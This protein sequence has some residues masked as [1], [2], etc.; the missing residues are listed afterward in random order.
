MVPIEYA[1]PSRHPQVRFRSHRA[2]R[3]LACLTQPIVPLL[4]Q[5]WPLRPPTGPSIMLGLSSATFPRFSSLLR[6]YPPPCAGALLCPAPSLSSPCSGAL[7]LHLPCFCATLA[8]FLFLPRCSILH[9]AGALPRAWLEL[10][11]PLYRSSRWRSARVGAGYAQRIA[12]A[13][14]D[15]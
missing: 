13:Q 7:P 10:P 8:V 2:H 3:M 11:S 6:H 12:P 5:Q 14:R 4:R 9:W 1:T 15:G